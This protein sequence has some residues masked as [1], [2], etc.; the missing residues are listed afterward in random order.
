MN[1]LPVAEDELLGFRPEHLQPADDGM[2]S[3][4]AVP[5]DAV[6]RFSYQVTRIE[7]LGADRLLYGTVD[8]YRGDP[9]RTLARLPSNVTMALEVGSTYPFA[10]IRAHRFDR[11]SGERHTARTAPK[12]RRQP[13]DWNRAS[14]PRRV[15]ARQLRRRSAD[16]H[17]RLADGADRRRPPAE[18]RF[19]R[20]TPHSRD[21]FA[22]TGTPTESRGKRPTHRAAASGAAAGSA[23]GGA[24]TGALPPASD[25]GAAT[26]GLLDNRRLMGFAFLAPAVVYIALLIGVPF[27]TAFAYSLSDATVGNTS[28]RYAGLPN[29]ETVLNAP[30]FH[31]ALR[32]TFVF[33]LVAQVFVLI[34]ANTLAL[35]LT[36]PLPQNRL[37]RGGM[38]G[39]RLLLIM[40]WA[41]PLALSVIGWL[42]MF[43]SK[44]SP[45]DYLLE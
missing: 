41:T 18:P 22:V 2:P 42:W 44:Y 5:A 27:V 25:T 10:V 31:A 6:R 33:T 28:F 37:V 43:D 38:W 1:L 39:A 16:C 17:R 23:S 19:R 7:Y 3:A 4:G 40:P 12:R 30:D 13:D 24:A 35:I 14:Q 9:H 45:I 26:V 20:R 34:L 32:N 36:A 8:D 21:Y 29:F 15:S 11:R